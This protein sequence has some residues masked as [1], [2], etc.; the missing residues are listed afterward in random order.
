MAFSGQATDDVGVDRVRVAIRD[1]ATRLWLQS[2]GTWA[3][4]FRQFDATLWSR[5]AAST[6]WTFSRALP[7]GQYGVSVR[8]VDTSAKPQTPDTWVTF[9]A[10]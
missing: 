3:A 4:T 8:A 9:S 2:N 7:A 1:Q 5:G 10:R 6:G